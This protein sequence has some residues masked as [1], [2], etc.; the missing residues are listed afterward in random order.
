MD[1]VSAIFL[2]QYSTRMRMQ[3]LGFTENSENLDCIT[4]DAFRVIS[5]EID[6]MNEEDAKKA[7]TKKR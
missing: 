1:E 6:R 4:F 2:A 5:D 3:K 7:K